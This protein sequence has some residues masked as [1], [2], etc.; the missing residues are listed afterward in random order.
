[1][2]GKKRKHGGG[3]FWFVFWWWMGRHLQSLPSPRCSGPAIQ[4]PY[5]FMS[6]AG[7]QDVCG[8][9]LAERDHEV[10]DPDADQCHP[11]SW[12]TRPAP[13]SAIP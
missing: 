12:R 1:M 4:H 2:L 11:A 10:I 5:F 7:C 13:P 6:H 3:F 9:K 8:P